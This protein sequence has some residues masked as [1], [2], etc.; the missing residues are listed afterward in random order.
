MIM[1]A[2][3]AMKNQTGMRGTL[4]S[5]ATNIKDFEFLSLCKD[6]G[7]KNKNA[8]AVQNKLKDYDEKN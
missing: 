3:T 5:K 1:R 6:I 4:V 7:T 2:S 8:R